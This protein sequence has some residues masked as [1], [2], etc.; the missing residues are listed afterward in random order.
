M[1]FIIENEKIVRVLSYYSQKT[2][3]VLLMPLKH[4]RGTLSR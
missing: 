1:K 3:K 2:S 4:D